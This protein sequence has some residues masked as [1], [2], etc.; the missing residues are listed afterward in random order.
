[1]ASFCGS[2][3]GLMDSVED[4]GSYYMHENQDEV[5]KMMQR[6]CWKTRTRQ[7]LWVYTVSRGT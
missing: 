5:P 4:K 3:V 6:L 1:M 2:L 7:R